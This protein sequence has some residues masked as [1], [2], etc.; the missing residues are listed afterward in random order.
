MSDLNSHDLPSHPSEQEKRQREFSARIHRLLF[1]YGEGE[2]TEW[3][4]RRC[5]Y[6]QRLAWGLYLA[7]SLTGD[8]PT[9]SE[10]EAAFGKTFA[11]NLRSAQ[12]RLRERLATEFPE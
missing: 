6:Y 2:I 12:S 8:S 4:I 9:N 11:N 7:W 10:I 3:V 5:S 1:E